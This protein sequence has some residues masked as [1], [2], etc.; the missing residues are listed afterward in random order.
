MLSGNMNLHQSE[1]VKTVHFIT[2]LID[3]RN[4]KPKNKLKT[5]WSMYSSNGTSHAAF[6]KTNTCAGTL[7]HGEHVPYNTYKSSSRRT[8]DAHNLGSLKSR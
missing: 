1:N 8:S 7:S 5:Q 4:K 3:M 6:I 2:G